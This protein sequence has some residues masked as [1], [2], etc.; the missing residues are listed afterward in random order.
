MKAIQRFW[1]PRGSIW[2]WM[3]VVSMVASVLP[4]QQV[5][6]QAADA[7]DWKTIGKPGFSAGRVSY[8][9]I[10]IDSSGT[11]Y[12]AYEDDMN[13][14]KAS[15]RKYNGSSWVTV[16]NDV[17]SAGN[18]SGITIALD[19]S[20]TPYVAYTDDANSNKATVKKYDGSRWV[21]VGTEGFS[22]NYTFYMSLA[23]DSNDTPYVAYKDYSEGLMVKKYDEGSWQDVGHTDIYPDLGISLAIDSYNIPY[24]AYM[25]GYPGKP[26]VIRYD[27]V[28]DQ[29]K[30]VGNGGLSESYGYVDIDSLGMAVDNSDTP[31]V[32]YQDPNNSYKAI[33][34]KYDGGNWVTVG[35][36][37]LSSG[38][39]RF[40]SIAIDSSGIPYVVFN[41]LGNE[42]KA[43]VMKYDGNRW[44][45]VGSAGISERS[46]DYT[47]IALNSK[48]IPYVVYRDTNSNLKAT[49]K[50]LVASVY[51]VSACR[52]R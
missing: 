30:T 47:K 8:T 32:V 27:G 10:A 38:R 48:G 5:I 34:K 14:G 4:L 42:S 25:D 29:W 33:V 9:S 46:A 50:A 13:F 21:T 39:A 2:I 36:S 15:V 44:V 41:D 31:Y 28:Q 7:A 45:T 26:R 11:P 20:D 51:T 23:I 52:S 12:V 40:N 37:G 18:T 19:S 3:L 6:V 49:V 24:V 43:V 1:K 22:A 35:A 16:G 17:F